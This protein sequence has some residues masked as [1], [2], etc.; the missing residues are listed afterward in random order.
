[1]VNNILESLEV[2]PTVLFFLL[3]PVHRTHSLLL[4]VFSEGRVHVH[5]PLS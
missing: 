3:A 1:M 4:A 5:Y 2:Q